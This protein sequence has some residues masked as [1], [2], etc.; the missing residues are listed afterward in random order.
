M[1]F[2]YSSNDIS[3]ALCDVGLK[4]GDIVF[5]HSNIGFLGNPVGGNY[6]ENVF[7]T[8]LN[9]FFDVIGSSGT[10][11]VPTFTYSFSRGR[12]F[13]PDKTP[14]D[15]GFLTEQIRLHP[16]AYR[17]EDPHVSVASIGMRADELT[18][19]VP[20][21]AY[22]T[23][24]FFDRFYKAD[25]VICNFNLDAAYVT[26]IHYIEKA[27]KVPYRFDKTFT[28]V[29]QKA[30]MEE[31]RKGTI[32]V[33]Y[34]TK[35]TFQ[36]PHA[37]NQLIKERNLYKVAKIG[38]GSIGLIKAKDMFNLIQEVIITRPWFLTEAELLGII[39]RCEDE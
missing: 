16:D 12:I 8:I 2:S 25:G 24:S 34:L 33:R 5:S 39:P 17:S 9:G 32:W 3:M 35:G 10:L 28:G 14:S 19:N 7:N 23:N 30:G 37:L 18:K 29:F 1:K 15:C 38:R 6:P 27:L 22:D 26:F 11:V 21:N 4:K 20:E 31:I 13:D 36:S